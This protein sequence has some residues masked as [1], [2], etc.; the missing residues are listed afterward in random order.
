M[1][2]K[3]IYIA[4]PLFTTAERR[5]NTA[6]ANAIS[7]QLDS[8]VFILPQDYAD[9]VSEHQD[10]LSEI[11]DH[12]I[13]SISQA[14]ALLCI[15]DGPDVDSGTSVEMGY[16]YARGIPIIGVRTD[17]RA[18]EENGVNLMVSRVC[19]ALLWKSHNESDIDVLAGEISRILKDVLNPHL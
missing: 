19:R 12:C 1:N 4:A 15:L 5:F 18:H 9:Q 17:F 14:D 6:L 7:K 3:T 11:F 13:E 16:A 10:C 2:T 8:F